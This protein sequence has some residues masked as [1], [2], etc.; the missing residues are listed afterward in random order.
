MSGLGPL[1]PLPDYIAVRSPSPLR[2]HLV[3]EPQQALAGRSP[4]P[5]RLELPDSRPIGITS[6]IVQLGSAIDAP[7][8]AGLSGSCS[9]ATRCF[10]ALQELHLAPKLKALS[11]SRTFSI[12]IKVNSVEDLYLPLH[13][14]PLTII[15]PC[16]SQ[17]HFNVNSLLTDSPA[18]S[19]AL[20][21]NFDPYHYLSIAVYLLSNKLSN[22]DDI[23]STDW[24][25]KFFYLIPQSLFAEVLQSDIFGVRAAWEVLISAKAMCKHKAMF[26][27]LVDIGS[28]RQWLVVH[29]M[30]HDYLYYAARANCH[31]MIEKLLRQ[32]CRPDC[33]WLRE[34]ESA[35]LEA[36]ENGAYE[37]AKLLIEHCDINAVIPIPNELGGQPGYC[38]NFQLFIHR[39]NRSDVRHLSGLEL[40]LEHEPDVD[41]PYID[42]DLKRRNYFFERLDLFY[43]TNK[44]P[45]NLRPTVLDHYFFIDRAVFKK[46]LPCSNSRSV[47]STLLH[48]LEQTEG[49]NC[50]RLLMPRLPIRERQRLLQLLL[51]EQFLIGTDYL[52]TQATEAWNSK[53]N[54]KMIQK[55]MEFGIH[56]GLSFLKKVNATDLLC[57]VIQHIHKGDL[58]EEEIATILS[59]LC[60]EKKVAFDGSRI[61]CA[62]VQKQ[63]TR[64]LNYFVDRTANIAMDGIK[65]IGEA[66][67]LDNFEAVRLLLDS[68][69]DIRNHFLEGGRLSRNMIKILFE[70]GMTINGPDPAPVDPFQLLLNLFETE[71]RD[72]YHQAVQLIDQL[73]DI[74]NNTKYCDSALLLEKCL[75]GPA[76]WRQYAERLNIFEHLFR[77]GALISPG[78]PLAVL[79]YAGGRKTLV[80]DIL[81]S[82]ADVNAYSQDF[83]DQYPK[84]IEPWCLTPLQAAASCGNEEAIVELIHRG[85]DINAPAVGHWGRTALQHICAWRPATSGERARKIRVIQ[86]FLESGAD[87]N[88]AAAMPSSAEST[89]LGIIA[90]EGDVDIATILLCYGADVNVGDS[91]SVLETAAFWGRL[92]MVQ[93][94]LNAGAVSAPGP[95]GKYVVAKLVAEQHGHFAVADL[96]EEHAN[97]VDPG[98]FS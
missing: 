44:I 15:Q 8:P 73:N 82:G 58:T 13:L 69:V 30:G 6:G 18:V 64:T 77:R 11:T 94:L 72:V 85:A 24:L 7:I 31:D 28:Q 36:I 65:A 68:G 19:T 47:R 46:L 78:S 54:V 42:D 75:R 16:E 1:S 87:I 10:E 70:R 39:F 81:V 56:L 86:K 88:A 71:S 40:F 97:K 41:A 74:K 63:G 84:W 80:D 43:S 34:S 3:P 25:E 52:S 67:Y 37:S 2:L 98:C 27:M 50:L 79:L 92:G 57:A 62:A 89:A 51:V 29:D 12:D 93:L 60:E 49:L 76:A 66:A 53:I 21:V 9:I 83:H 26:R 4:S 32:G 35:I 38:T 20:S 55:L 91:W 45:V 5:F 61:L 17:T 95:L 59:L 96:I 33:G 22:L 23:R 90:A 48:K 14:I